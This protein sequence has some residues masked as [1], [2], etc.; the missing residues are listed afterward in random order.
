[1]SH[2]FLG[3]PLKRKEDL[4]HLTGTGTFVDDIKLPRT[5]YATLLRSPHANARI[6]RIDANKA[7]A[8]PTVQLV[9]T[10]SDLTDGIK[11][12]PAAR[13]SEKLQSP[14][15][16]ALAVSS[17]KYVGQPVA[18]LVGSDPFIAEDALDLIE[19][20][21]EPFPA[22][23]DP[24]AAM[25]PNSPKV[26]QELRDNIAYHA[27]LEGGDLETAFAK[28]DHIF[29]FT[30]ANQR[31]AA[32]AL[33]PRGV[34]ANYNPGEETLTVWT[35]TQ[36]P[37]DVRT[38]LAKLLN[39]PENR[40]RVIAPDVGGGFGSKISL[41]PEE[42]L[43]A[44]ASVKLQKPVKWIESRRENFLATSH[45]RGQKH[46]V[47]VAVMEDGRILALKTRITADIGAYNTWETPYVP[48][49]T[50]KMLVGCYNL[51]A[52][53]GEL[54]CL[55]TNKV[56][57][58]PYRGAG[59]P[60]ATF[61]IERV[62]DLLARQ[63]GLDSVEVRLRNFIPK[64]R[65]PYATLTGFTY[66]SGNYE[67]TL[68]TAVEK[69]HYD[70]WRKLQREARQKGRYLGIGFS[71]Y[72]EI[73]GFG[74][75][76][77]QAAQVQV[78]RSG[79]VIVN[80]ST[81]PHG[82]GHETPFAQIVSDELGIPV[83]DVIVQYGDTAT[84]PWGLLTAGSRGAA[85][86]GSAVLLA[87]RR[88]REKMAAV[89]AKTLDVT[90][91][92]L[93][94]EAGQV[95][96]TGAEGKTIEFARVARIAYDPRRLPPEIEPSLLGYAAFVP[97]NYTFPFGTHIVVLEVDVETGRVEVL[98]YV[99]VDD[100]GTEL[101]PLII[102]GQVHGGVLQGIGQSL[103]EGM[104]YNSDGQLL[105]PTFTE[106]S[107]PTAME[108]PLIEPYR[109]HTPTPVNPLGSK[110]IGEV[111]AIAATP[112]I[113]NAIED[114]LSPLNV[115]ITEMPATPELVHKLC[116]AALKDKHHKTG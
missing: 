84:L 60:E 47:E 5:L 29:H 50:L 91:Q 43:V 99:A 2:S 4:R 115:T 111:G 105:S 46:Y 40:V 71:S 109:T 34:V 116:A 66:D 28:A 33:E 7:R 79:K 42:A 53:R 102:D 31:V 73:C 90:P 103:Y 52:Y 59:R 63:L 69:V 24:E 23:V 114:A 56:N 26:H 88:V 35:S 44:F 55:F 72:V 85:L 9:L 19:V 96:G 25:E 17:V 65:F 32:A 45:G 76:T 41:Y 6:A 82:Q 64:D 51:E 94:F 78:L 22:V 81:S 86:G 113:V 37:Y 38:E 12:L 89:A 108:A 112:A 30:L 101:N 13:P 48:E 20:D 14:P 97:Q 87:V 110:G 98:K 10:A 70:D 1:M 83:E 93:R 62:V 36:A 3:K 21:Y 107:M 92:E 11:S 54:L 16:P 67:K 61:I 57:T 39:L 68:K 106:Y 8:C 75:E 58:D 15:R 95:R 80:T 100:V 104:V 27:T 49:M 74:P 18:L 77:F